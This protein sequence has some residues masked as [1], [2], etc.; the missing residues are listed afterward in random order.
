MGGLLVTFKIV[1]SWLLGNY[2][3]GGFHQPDFLG[4][5]TYGRPGPDGRRYSSI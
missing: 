4:C 2:Q 3:M 5:P 1:G